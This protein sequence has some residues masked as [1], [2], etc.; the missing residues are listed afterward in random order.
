M[1]SG[2]SK[3]QAN[4]HT[5][6][7]SPKSRPS[8]DVRPRRHAPVI[9]HSQPETI[10]V[11]SLND[12]VEEVDFSSIIEAEIKLDPTTTGVS[13]EGSL[14]TANLRQKESHEIG[15]QEKYFV[16]GD[17][18]DIVADVQS[19][20]HGCVCSSVSEDINVYISSLHKISMQSDEIL[21]QRLSMMTSVEA[22]TITKLVQQRQILIEQIIKKGADEMDK[23]EGH[24]RKIIEEFIAKLEVEMSKHLD[25]LQARME[26]E[27]TMV[28]ESSHDSLQLLAVNV[29][30]AKA[31]LLRTVE[32]STTSKRQEILRQIVQVSSDTKR[33][34]IGY[35]QLRKLN[36]DIYSTVGTKE[37]VQG[38]DK[39]TDRNKYKKLINDA[40]PHQQMKRT[41][42]LGNNPNA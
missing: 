42:F 41:L 16:H 8:A 10:D 29:Q 11:A 5:Q 28:F 14:S 18:S 1:G 30:E 24:Y 21:K 20:V 39:I 35:E 6:F 2:S 27:K 25:E 13:T 23:S 40:K 31:K 32:L 7:P 37:D 15:W 9:S 17:S 36:M 19:Q 34:L 33:Q 22:A 12:I 26:D 38:C 4:K 3:R